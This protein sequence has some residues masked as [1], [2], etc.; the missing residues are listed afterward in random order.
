LQILI[1]SPYFF[2]ANKV[3]QSPT[4]DLITRIPALERY[5]VM[6]EYVY[7]MLGMG[8]MFILLWIL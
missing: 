3:I 8:V 2:V 7:M 4:K 1:L 5:K 6:I